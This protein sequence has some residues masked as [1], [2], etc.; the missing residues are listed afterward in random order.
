MIKLEIY[1]FLPISKAIELESQD[2][3]KIFPF[4]QKNINKKNYLLVF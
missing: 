2:K 4:K 1:I 3:V